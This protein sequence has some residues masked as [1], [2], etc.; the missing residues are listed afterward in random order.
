MFHKRIIPVL[1]FAC[2]TPFLSAHAVEEGTVGAKKEQVVDAKKEGAA[3]PKREGVVTIDMIIHAR[4]NGDY[5]LALELIGRARQRPLG[6]RALVTLSLYEGILLYEVGRF[7]ESGD[8]FEMALLIEPDATLPKPVSPKIE[9]HFETVRKKAQQEPSTTSGGKQKPSPRASTNCPSGHIIPPGR[10]LKAQ[11]LWRLAMMEQMLCLRD[12]RGG[13]V[14]RRLSEFKAQV[15]QA[16]SPTEWVRAIQEVDQF[17]KEYAVYPF[18]AD[19]DHAKSLVPEERWELGDEDQDVALPAAPESP[20]EEPASL[21]GCRAAVVPDCERLM[22]RLLLLQNQISGVAS[23]KQLT[24]RAELLRLGRRVREAD[25]KEK[26]RATTL[27]IDTW[28]STWH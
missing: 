18:K 6:T 7:V 14:A 28:Q 23:E 15:S 4:Q 5:E 13:E 1:L 21:F 10:T 20:D 8:A 19:W 12:I 16:G 3:D 11:Q 2:W 22:R 27:D 9:S 17:A 26:L 24:A 25:T